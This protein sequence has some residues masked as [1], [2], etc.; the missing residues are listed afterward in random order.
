MMRMKR[1]AIIP[2]ALKMCH[3]LLNNLQVTSQPL[4][5]NLQEK[6]DYFIL[7]FIDKKLN[8][9]EIPLFPNIIELIGSNTGIQI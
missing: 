8:I 4:P 7:N 2:W 5:N 6:D 3:T 1:A 9:R